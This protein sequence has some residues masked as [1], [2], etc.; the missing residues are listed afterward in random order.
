[1]TTKT[2]G[3]ALGGGGAKGLAHVAM[4]EVL[5]DLGVK[6][7]MIAG[8]SAGAIIGCFYAS[9]ASAAEVREMLDELVT[10]PESFSDLLEGKRPFRWLDYVDLDIFG[11]SNILAVDKLL[12]HLGEEIGVTTFE[13][14]SIPLQVVAADFWSRREVVLSSGPI[15]P[16]VAA[17]FALPGVFEPVERD[18]RILIDGGVVNPVPY[19]HLNNHCD[20]T[21]AIDVMGARSPTETL[22]PSF[23]EMIFN[24]IQIAQRSILIEKMKT[25]PPTV[26]VD[27]QIRDVKVL[28]FNKAARIYAQAEPFKRQLRAQLEALI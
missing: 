7:A 22:Q 21:V 10:Q 6:P 23:T 27:V 26:Y 12:E 13:E 11:R 8:T 24:S 17:S 20:I 28:E 2:V 18:G 4:L 15:V 19:D 3:I 16:A 5:D 14:L 9:G 1:M 25:Q